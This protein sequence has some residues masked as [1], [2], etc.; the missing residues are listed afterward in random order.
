MPRESRELLHSTARNVLSRPQYP[1]MSSS[2]RGDDGRPMRTSSSL[3]RSTFTGRA[4]PVAIHPENLADYLLECIHATPP[5]SRMIA[6]FVI[7]YPELRNR[8][9][10]YIFRSQ[11][12]NADSG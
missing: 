2:Q 7:Y 1:T 12:K 4:N 9:W 6:S 10:G 8:S 5:L 11:N 3:V